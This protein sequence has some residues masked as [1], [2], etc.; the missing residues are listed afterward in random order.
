MK[1]RILSGIL[2]LC[3]LL[4]TLAGCGKKETVIATQ[5][6]IEIPIGY[7]TTQQVLMRVQLENRYGDD[8]EEHMAAPN[9]SDPTKTNAQVY[10]ETYQRAFE[11][12]WLFKLKVEE[13]GLEMDE[14]RLAYFDKEYEYFKYFFNSTADYR[15]F[16]K[17]ANM[18][19]EEHKQIY[20][21]SVYYSDL[22]YA[23]FYDPE[24][25]TERIDEVALREYF[26]S[27]VDY[28]I[29][30]ILFAFGE[31]K[32]TARKE[33]EDV[34]AKLQGGEIEFD[35]AM[36]EYSDDSDLASYP[37]GY[38]FVENEE[39]FPSVF[40]TAAKEL[41]VDEYALYESDLGYHIIKRISND[42]YFEDMQDIYRQ[43]Y[44]T[45]RLQVKYDAW[46]EE[47][48]FVYNEAALKEYD[49][50][51]AGRTNVNLRQQTQ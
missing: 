1:T 9:E 46:L 19:E 36:A 37:D 42:T 2:A 26:D 45:E 51:S 27:L 21:E 40:T 12:L 38:G 28:S 20:M 48:D 47:L 4:G 11:M 7:Y 31:D 6:G 10:N 34:L 23:Y 44:G 24:V 22:I 25:G 33:A 35:D 17:A 13:L 43:A 49:F 14:I 3:L 18:T 16:L 29:K 8:Y 15:L 50:Q 32:A 5:N 41:A 39:G 30:H